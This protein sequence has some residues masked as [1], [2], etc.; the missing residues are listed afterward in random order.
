M[1][2][3]KPGTEACTTTDVSHNAD[4][5]SEQLRL[6]A[7]CS[8]FACFDCLKAEANAEHA[9]AAE[10]AAAQEKDPQKRAEMI[11]KQARYASKAA[12]ADANR[13]AAEQKM[14]AEREADAVEMKALEAEKQRAAQGEGMW[15]ETGSVRKKKGRHGRGI[16]ES[17][18]PAQ[19]APPTPTFR[20]GVDAGVGGRA[21]KMGE[22]K[23]EPRSANEV[24]AGGGK[25]GWPKKIMSKGENQRNGWGWK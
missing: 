11:S 22:F 13:K 10:A 7:R 24:D 9:A 15:I 14:K 18:S 8:Y 6:D 4:A 5:F 12:K 21:G 20:M 23:N 17:R 1:P 19:S 3:S 25:G 2:A 16:Y